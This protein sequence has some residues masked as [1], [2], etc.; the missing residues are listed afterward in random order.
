VLAALFFDPRKSS[1]Q[2]Q[3]GFAYLGGMPHPQAFA[4]IAETLS[5][6]DNWADRYR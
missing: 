4:E 2:S 1:L 5:F 3:P 6:L